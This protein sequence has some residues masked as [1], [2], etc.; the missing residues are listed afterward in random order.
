MP[1]MISLNLLLLKKFISIYLLI[2]A[3]CSC[4][5]SQ[6]VESND[7][8]GFNQ[9]RRPQKSKHS[10]NDVEQVKRFW[11]ISDSTA[12]VG[13]IFN[14]TISNDAF[15]G[16][17]S[18]FVVTE[19]GEANLPVWL[20]FNSR[21]N[22]LQGLPLD[23]DVGQ[24]YISVK[25]YG[26]GSSAN[27]AKDVF[28]IDV[29]D[30][31]SDS[32][33]AIHKCSTGQVLTVASVLLDAELDNVSLENKIALLEQAA[34]T[35]KLP[36]DLVKLKSLCATSRI[37]DSS[38]VMAG[39]GN[40]N[41]P[42]TTGAVIQW[43]VGCSG[44]V[45]PDQAKL[46]SEVEKISKDGSFAEELGFPVIGWHVSNY[47]QQLLRREK[48]QTNQISGT[49]VPG[50]F[51]SKWPTI[52]ER[53]DEESSDETYAPESRVIPTMISPSFSSASHKH[54]HHHGDAG[55]HERAH[56]Y[57]SI[58]ITASP[59]VFHKFP[60]TPVASVMTTP[61][62][63]TERPS[64][65]TP[66]YIT[67]DSPS[68][69]FVEEH[70]PVVGIISSTV[71][72]TT[73]SSASVSSSIKPTKPIQPPLKPSV[74]TPMIK[75]RIK[76]LYMVVGKPWSYQIPPDT[77][78][79][80]ED[81]NT[82]NLKLL[83]MTE[84]RT[85]VEPASWIQFDPEKQLLYALPLDEDTGKYKF[86]LEAMDS[87][88][89]TIQDNLDIHVRQHPGYRTVH[90]VFTLSL[91]FPKWRFPV[92]IDWQREVVKKL[93]KFYGDKN[94][95]HITVR[96][97][98]LDPIKISW[99][100]DTLPKHPCPNHE[101]DKLA[102]R[103]YKEGSR[104]VTNHLAKAM[105][106]LNITVEDASVTLMGICQPI[107]STTPTTR[108]D[109][110]PVLRNPIEQI[111][112]TVGEILRFEVPKDTFYDEEDGDTRFLKLILFG[113]DS[114]SVPKSY[115]VQLNQ[116][117]QE[118]YG[119]PFE[120]DTGNHEFIMAAIDSDGHTVNEAFIIVVH[121]RVPRKSSV[122]FSLHIEA[123]YNEFSRN[124]T[125]KTL[126]AWKLCRLY[127]DPDP[128][129]ITVNS[130]T[131]GSVVYS[132]T[133][134]T[135]PYDPCPKDTITNLVTYLYNNNETISSQLIE[136]MKPDFKVIKV[137]VIPLKTCLGEVPV[138]TGNVPKP[139]FVPEVTDTEITAED[140]DDIYITTIIPAVVIVIMLI[141]A[142]MVACFLYRKKR[143]GK[144]RMN[145]NGAFVTKG[146]P[147]IFA[148][149]L[150]DKSDPA[151][152]PIILK[153]E[154]PPLA[155]VDYPRSIS[156]SS[157]DSTPQIDRREVSNL[158][159]TSADLHHQDPHFSP[160]YQPP[161]PFTS[162]RDNKN[163]RPKATPTYRQPPPYVPP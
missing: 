40:V 71:I 31:S 126:I 70:T 97:V 145:D 142:A 41:K 25:A 99:T 81:G 36:G 105:R 65:Y 79:D 72:A 108:T 33:V 74:S 140:D 28:S 141:I 57:E 125:Q 107:A 143:K 3:L 55:P 100:N 50:I 75:N 56:P 61:M 53:I 23:K 147:I 116:Q 131:K 110:G 86:I 94:A 26:H 85:A 146:I 18:N 35:M 77:Y 111:N 10:T 45:S 80:N 160:P 95:S 112:A 83:F 133:N 84:D 76:K 138:T 14:Y 115:W 135:L 27:V 68:R 101:I 11:G 103:L 137:D 124:I 38:A 144:M 17:I 89:L 34:L 13:Q 82:R 134:N 119:L 153:E 32:S 157:R 58:H 48:R 114:N 69:H 37:F 136:A 102:R 154:K 109:T 104:S 88:G 128:R 161:P 15:T 59:A 30:D 42:K 129:Y 64:K 4:A 73:D 9:E 24:Y 87:D 139:P 49:P 93:G 121:P 162:S 22:T 19:A 47:Q 43:Q 98:S 21:T 158:R 2:S 1:N 132:W 20:K 46:L 127:G 149:E 8:R 92:A 156:A 106:E 51:P 44:I 62:L 150:D 123:D 159:D 66:S 6:D 152:P 7:I 78:V 63:V 96:G 29:V 118:L 151:K 54:R 130:I 91:K 5:L 67:I 155:P 52:T 120:G 163:S 148:D 39:P 90:H 117:S 113:I 16:K 12:I 122:E 60:L